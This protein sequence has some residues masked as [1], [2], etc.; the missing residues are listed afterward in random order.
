MSW[1]GRKFILDIFERSYGRIV[2]HRPG[3]LARIVI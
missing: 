2:I 1:S 3:G